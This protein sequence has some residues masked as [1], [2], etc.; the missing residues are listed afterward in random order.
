MTM[1]TLHM[2]L[3]Q[4]WFGMTVTGEKEEEYREMTLYW[5]QRLRTGPKNGVCHEAGSCNDCY[6]NDHPQCR[7][8]H[9]DT[10]TMRRGYRKTDPMLVVEHKGT[11]I[12]TG[13]PEWGAPDHPVFILANGKIL[14]TSNVKPPCTPTATP[15]GE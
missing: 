8:K 10:R 6:Y 12:G 4:P 7:W 11:T 13:R 3:K 5:K 15:Q 14:E 2:T 9:Y 1:K